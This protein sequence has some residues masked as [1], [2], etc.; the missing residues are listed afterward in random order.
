VNFDSDYQH[1]AWVKAQ[2][3]QGD[4][5]PLWNYVEDH[6]TLQPEQAMF[7]ADVGRGQIKR[8]HKHNQ[9]K[10][11]TK[12]AVHFYETAAERG[13]SREQIMEAVRETQGSSAEASRKAIEHYPDKKTKG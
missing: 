1:W 10:E 6:P 4:D 5:R 7:V 13:Y 9:P 2:F 8:G 12:Q 11:S 3:K